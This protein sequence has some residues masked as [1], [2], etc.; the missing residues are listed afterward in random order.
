MKKFNVRVNGKQYEVEVE[1]LAQA[2]FQQVTQAAPVA[3]PVPAQPVQTAPAAPSPASAQ[4]T[5]TSNQATS[6]SGE[7]VLSPMPGNIW[8]ILVSVG[9]SVN[10]GDTLLIL[11][12]LKMENEIPAPV[13]GIVKKINVQEGSTVNSGDILVELE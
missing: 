6:G 8:K 5:Q 3:T 7:K 13:S 10:S 2:T 9:D 1:E 4:P 11:E 12:A